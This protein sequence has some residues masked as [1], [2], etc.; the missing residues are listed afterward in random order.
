MVISGTIKLRSFFGTLASFFAAR[1]CSAVYNAPT[2]SLYVGS[3]NSGIWL[4]KV[5]R[6]VKFLAGNWFSLRS[7][8]R[9]SVWFSRV[10]RKRAYAKRGVKQTRNAH[11]THRDRHAALDLVF[12]AQNALLP[13]LLLEQDEEE[14]PT[15][16]R[17]N[18]V[19]Q[20]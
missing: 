3:K 20:A 6:A 8:L 1:A 11:E 9:I 12:S 5:T 14:A 7:S 10:A 16:V 17:P 18:A 19:A 15:A 2:P 4:P 13:Q